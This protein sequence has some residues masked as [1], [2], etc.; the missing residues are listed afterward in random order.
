MKKNLKTLIIVGYCLTQ[1][2]THDTYKGFK[3]FILRD[4]KNEDAIKIQTQYYLARTCEA[5]L[6][7]CILV[8]GAVPFINAYSNEGVAENPLIKVGNDMASAFVLKN[9]KGEIVFDYF[10]DESIE[11]FLEYENLI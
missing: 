7:D 5:K 11:E 2:D 9:A 3:A 10:S 8:N 6:G 4:V 1:D